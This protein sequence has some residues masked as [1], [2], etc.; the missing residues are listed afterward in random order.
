MKALVFDLRGNGGGYL[1]TAV[2][3]AEYFL[4]RGQTIVTTRA[5]GEDKDRRTSEGGKITDVP[6][7]VLV[8][9]GSASASEILAGCLRDHD[10]GT[11][12]GEKTFGKGSV[13]DLKYL[14]ATE[15]KTAVRVTISKWFLPKGES[16]EKDNPK[17]NGIEPQ[18]KVTAPERDFWKDAEFE[19][20]RGGEEIEKYLN[21]HSEANRELFKNLAE[22]DGNDPARYPGFDAFYD[23]LKT[24]ASKEEVRELLRDT[25]RKHVQDEQGKPLYFDFQTDAVLQRAILEACKKANIDANRIQEYETFARADK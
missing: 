1:K 20:I 14:K 16:V 22:A 7:Y 2:R 13:Q 8:D 11:L 15:E 17:E 9:E 12:I 10:R 18:I 24:K 23:S 25:V 4:E 5:R 19:R 6:L 3:I 21:E